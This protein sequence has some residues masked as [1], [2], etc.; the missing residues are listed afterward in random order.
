MANQLYVNGKVFTGEGE[1]QFA[2]AFRT[3]DG[4]FSW[5][6]KLVRCGRRGAPAGNASGT[7]PVRAFKGVASSNLASPTNE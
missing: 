7:S 2:S 6:G 5:V 4:V 3:T 1:T